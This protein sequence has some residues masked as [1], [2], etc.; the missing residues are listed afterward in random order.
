MAIASVSQIKLMLGISG[1]SEDA[2]LAALLAAASSAIISYTGMDFESHSFGS[3][4][5]A[6]SYG[7]GDSGYYSGENTRFLVLRQRPVTAIASI[8]QDPTGRFGDNPDGSYA[9]DS[10][11]VAG[12]D[13]VLRWDGTLPGATT[14]CSYC[15][16]VERINGIW[17]GM[18][19]Y[20]RGTINPALGNHQG[21]IKV[22]YTAGY[23]T[24]PSDI[25][26]AVSL[27]VATMRRSAVYGGMSVNSEHFE[28][29]GYTLGSV[30][31]SAI[32]Q[33]GELRQILARYKDI[34]I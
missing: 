10:L 26:Y 24:V 15:A 34:P 17:P 1:S 28:D 5:T 29:Y 23:T 7:F 3:G 8:Y 12:T 14:R 18:F 13:Y 25:V 33:I 4:A 6:T 30:G 27:L 31:S 9:S 22:T 19:M 32:T 11:L 21:N 16:I 2:R 20:Q